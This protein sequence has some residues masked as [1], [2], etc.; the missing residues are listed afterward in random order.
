[1]ESSNQEMK[2]KTNPKNNKPLEKTIKKTT[3]RI[4]NKKKLAETLKKKCIKRNRQVTE[5]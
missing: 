1:M 2:D 3:A 5:S 4:K